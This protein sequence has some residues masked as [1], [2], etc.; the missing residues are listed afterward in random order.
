MMA[1]IGILELCGY[2]TAIGGAVTALF[3]IVR[4]CANLV[5]M[6]VEE[7]EKAMRVV[8]D[9]LVQAT[10]VVTDNLAQATKAATDNLAHKLANIATK[11]DALDHQRDAD[12]ERI[13][14][15]ETHFLNAEKWQERIEKQL[16]RITEALQHRDRG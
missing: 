5:A 7:S 11:V 14:K 8:T 16:D 6:K 12:I 3:G 10:K 15:L 13:V 1:D 4:W 9:N 2:L